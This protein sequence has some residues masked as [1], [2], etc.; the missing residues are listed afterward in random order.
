MTEQLTA[1]LRAAIKEASPVASRFRAASRHL[2]FV[3]GVIRD[4]LAG[5]VRDDADYDMTTDARPDEIKALIG[6]IADAVWT[7]GERFGTIGCRVGGREYEIT[8]HRADA[9]DQASRKPIVAFGDQIEADLAR[10]DFTINAIA[11][12]VATADLVDPFDGRSDLAD[13]TLR[14]PL[15]PSVSFSD[16]PLR[17]LRAARFVATFGFDPATELTSAVESMGERMAIVSVERVRDELQKLLMLPNPQPG[18]EFL[19]STGLITHVLPE[20]AASLSMAEPHWSRLAAVVAEPGP[21]WA[22][23]L[24]DLPARLRDREIARLKP[25]GQLSALVAWFGAGGEWLGEGTVPR[26][27]PALRRAAAATPKGLVIEQRL[28][29]V[30]QLRGVDDG[31]GSADV[32]AARAAL[33]RLRKA[34][35]DL[36]QPV[37]VLTGNEIAG[38]LGIE[39]GRLIGEALA[40]LAQKRFDDGPFGQQVARDILMTWWAAQQ[41]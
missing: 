15:D 36:D 21:R 1:G 35:P 41:T 20:L 34:E 31:A 33:S 17:M 2:Y 27:K 22:A 3:G 11:L 32:V 16:D 37:P 30:A 25:S 8:T 38:L 6:P 29:F 39:P 24:L 4:E 7:Q 23:L 18:F 40:V 10:R 5:R 28:D 9:Y 12:N 14:T 19:H 13:G 26:D